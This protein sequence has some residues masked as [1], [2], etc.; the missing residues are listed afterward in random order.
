[1]TT[2]Q[3]A[4]IAVLFA[5]VM[6]VFCILGFFALTTL[7]PSRTAVLMVIVTATPSIPTDTPSTQ[8]S[9]TARSTAT[10]RPARP[11]DTTRPPTV[12]PCIQT[13]QRIT[14]PSSPFNGG[15][16]LPGCSKLLIV[17][18]TVGQ[19]LALSYLGYNSQV[20]MATV[21]D[22]SGALMEGEGAAGTHY[23]VATTTGDYTITFQGKGQLI[24][25]IS[26]YAYQK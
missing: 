3:R 24:F 7:S 19:V 12:P 9:P 26:W 23:Y 21:R 17:R 4:I 25:G 2:R 14:S 10:D 15:E 22:P 5:V 1:M 18:V 20:S 6:I 8:P 13:T 11:T 16:M